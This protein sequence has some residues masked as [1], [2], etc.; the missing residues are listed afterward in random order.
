MKDQR[1]QA[2]I[3]LG[4]AAFMAVIGTVYWFASYEPAG[5]TM[6]GLSSALA[7]LCGI[8]LWVQSEHGDTVP[9]GSGEEHYLPHSSVW[10]FGMGVGALLAVN[11]MV[12]GFGYAIPG[13]VVLMIAIVGL[14]S[15]SRRRA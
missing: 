13:V 8:Y 15:Q 3:F 10:P 1:V 4:I 14:I 5:T 7:A 6:L 9:V 2:R 11:G 12:V